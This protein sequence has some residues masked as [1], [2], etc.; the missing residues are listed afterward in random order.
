VHIEAL[1]SATSYQ[2]KERWGKGRPLVPEKNFKNLQQ[3]NLITIVAM[4]FKIR[5]QKD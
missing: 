4:S 1:E 2:I 5:Y 3:G